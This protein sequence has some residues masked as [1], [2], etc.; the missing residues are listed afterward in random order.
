MSETS[1]RY[2]Q[3]SPVKRAY[4]AL[5]KA[6][7]RLESLERERREG[8]AVVGMACR[9]PGSVN[10]PDE[11]WSL[12]TA[13]R[14]AITEVP[15][16]R[17]DINACFDPDPDA[18]GK[19]GSR[20]GG[21]IDNVDQF[22]AAFFGISP[23]E[24]ESLDPQQ[25]LLLEVAQE[26][27]EEAGLAGDQLAGSPTG[28]FVGLAN[29]D[30]YCLLTGQGR[31][32]ID[33][34]MGTGTSPN[35]AAGRV[36]YVFGLRGPCVAIDTACS[37]S[38][39]AIHLACQALRHNECRMALAGGVNVMLTPDMSITFTKAHML[40]PD[41]RCKTFDADANGYV[42]GEG[43]GLLLLKRLSEAQADGDRIL[44]VIRGSAVNHAG[45][46]GGLTVPNGPA[47]QEVIRRALDGARMQ[48]DEID[49]VEAHGTGTPLGDPIEVGAIGA[50]FAG[51]SRPLWM[52]SVKTNLGHLEAAA[53]IAGV[54]K[55]ILALQHAEIPP[56]L[57]FRKPSFKIPWE[58]LSVRVPT[59]RE[60]WPARTQR[61]AAGVSSFGFSGINAHVVI[62]EAP[63][64]PRETRPPRA[65]YL[66]PLSAKHPN[67]LRQLAARF[68]QHLAQ[69]PAASLADVCGAAAVGRAHFE[70]R[71][72]IVVGSVDE[73]RDALQDFSVGRP[74]ART[75]AG[76]QE[77][78]PCRV[79]FLLSGEETKMSGAAPW[80]YDTEPV[81]RAAI[82]QCAEILASSLSRPLPQILRDPAPQD[83]PIDSQLLSFA[84]QYAAAQLWQSWGI[85]PAVLFGEGVGAWVAAC[86]AGVFSLEQTLKWIIGQRSATGSAGSQPQRRLILPSTGE[87]AVDSPSMESMEE[88][89]RTAADL[90]RVERTLAAEGVDTFLE[91]GPRSPLLDGLRTHREATG[92]G[93]VARWHRG[94]PAAGEEW[95]GLFSHLAEL[96]VTGASV[97]WRSVAQPWGGR[98]VSL[99]TYPFQRRRYWAE[100]PE[101][102]RADT[103]RAE[104]LHPLLGYRVYSAA[105]A[106]LVQFENQLLANRPPFLDQHR[107]VGT[108]ILPAAGFFEIGLATAR[109]MSPDGDLVVEGMVLE[110]AMPFPMSERR[111]VQTALRTDAGGYRVELYSRPFRAGDSRNPLPWTLHATGRIAVPSE[112]SLP[113]RRNLDELMR[114]CSREVPLDDFYGQLGRRG[115][116]YGPLF[117]GLKRL[118]AGDGEAMGFVEL[119][120]ASLH[121]AEEYVLYPPVADACLHVTAE[122]LDRGVD[123]ASGVTVTYVP[124][125]AERIRFFAPPPP[126]LW[127]YARLRSSPSSGVAPSYEIDLDLLAPDG[128]AVA[129]IEGL[130]V[131]QINVEALARDIA[132][133]PSEQEGDAAGTAGKLA[134]E[135]HG[136][137]ADSQRERL[138]Q[139]LSELAARILKLARHEPPPLH[140]SLFELGLDSLMSV[141]LLYRINQ[142]LGI[143]LSMQT[144][145]ENAAIAPLADAIVRELRVR[146]SASP[147]LDASSADGTPPAPSPTVEEKT[148][149]RAVAAARLRLVC[150]APPQTELD[151]F[152]G[153]A[154]ALQPNIEVCPLGWPETWQDARSRDW[155]QLVDGL[156]EKVL[157]LLDRP[158]A[159][160][161]SGS[162]GLLAF[163]MAQAIKDRFGLT[164]VHLIVATACPPESVQELLASGADG[165]L[166]YAG[167]AHRPRPP[168]DCPL[169][170]LADSPS[171]D[172][173][174]E[175]ARG[176]QRWTSAAFRLESLPDSSELPAGIRKI[177]G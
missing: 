53:G 117:Q 152:A 154:A 33:A 36:S 71:L 101:M 119:P 114:R 81:F 121:E 142:A 130:R 103:P 65:L 75:R 35:S 23:R 112:R 18:P 80:L 17:W 42:R 85:R 50:V 128:T 13:G 124:V 144:L 157:D 125:A 149:P 110:Q 41:G 107:L 78:D 135:I 95:E 54:I 131:Q 105:A 66:L 177:I 172:I 111:I 47:Q 1:S 89:L 102:S 100:L 140:R 133:R 73:A 138:V 14:D 86:L 57:H 115:L 45:A 118:R 20:F 28:V 84:V 108:P 16:E 8:I 113:C 37:S 59:R 165:S 151:C 159:L 127:S 98:N 39:V 2:E 69:D 136:L 120:P 6:Q 74:T 38:L 72:A 62:E 7:S 60:P 92:R 64:L 25:R 96:Y 67:A 51:R 5:E 70:H 55:V 10:S 30:Y 116:H 11:Y 168:L 87:I 24:A 43:V 21:F 9:F 29:G 27:F 49:Y 40:C 137:P 106:E 145:L 176:W 155:V 97:D 32:R 169:T 99:P 46:S 68:A 76:A 158:F 150:F 153:W 83:S 31:E 91:I 104:T 164:P 132:G 63:A 162:G 174:R 166:G 12:L 94:F 175:V 48:P 143:N 26:T 134:E 77:P 123:D 161:G 82:D 19:V 58:D 129:S 167:Y 126:T 147:T 90:A 15:A 52:G 44:A 3:L 122:L 156:A 4:L 170:V 93:G 139:F 171:G 160:F 88:M 109:E 173:G 22:D 163:E 79:A 148:S 56:H 141:E 146:R 34:Y 61:R